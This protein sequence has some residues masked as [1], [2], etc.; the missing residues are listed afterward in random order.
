[1]ILQPDVPPHLIDLKISFTTVS[2]TTILADHMFAHERLNDCA[3]CAHY[4][5]LCALVACHAHLHMFS[6]LALD[7]LWHSMLF[8]AREE[9]CI[10]RLVPAPQGISTAAQG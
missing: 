9:V 2:P 5:R 6:K 10:F 1:M 8:L 4:V 7:I 3:Q